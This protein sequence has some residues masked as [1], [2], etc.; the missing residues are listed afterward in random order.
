MYARWKHNQKIY[1]QTLK[2]GLAEWKDGEGDDVE[3]DHEWMI[4]R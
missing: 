3:W 4:G 1:S 2:D